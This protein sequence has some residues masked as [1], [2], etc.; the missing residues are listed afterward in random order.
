[1]HDSKLRK[2]WIFELKRFTEYK[3]EFTY[4][5]SICTYAGYFKTVKYK[6]KGFYKRLVRNIK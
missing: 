3:S 6:F 4:V 5:I 1:M 2:T